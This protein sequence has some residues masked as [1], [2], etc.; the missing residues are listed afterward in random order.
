MILLDVEVMA[1]DRVVRLVKKVISVEDKITELIIELLGTDVVGLGI[2][3]VV[4]L[5]VKPVIFVD[6]DTR[7]AVA[8]VKIDDEVISPDDRVN[9]LEK[10]DISFVVKVTSLDVKLISLDNVVIL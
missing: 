3:D 1:L 10:E 5:V 2:D 7:D 6:W 4:G 8:L 9:T